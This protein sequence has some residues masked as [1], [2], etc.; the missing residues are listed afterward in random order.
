MGIQKEA[1]MKPALAP[2]P[3]SRRDG[4]TVRYG[5]IPHRTIQEALA[6]LDVFTGWKNPKDIYAFNKFKSTMEREQKKA[7]GWYNKLITK[8]VEMEEVNAK[9]ADGTFS[10]VKDPAT[11]KIKMRAK[12][13]R[14]GRGEQDMVF[15][16]QA[17]FERDLKIFHD[18]TFTVKVH[19]FFVEDLL[20]A[21]LTPVELRSC[22]AIVEEDLGLADDADP[23]LDDIPEDLLGIIPGT[24]KPEEP[25]DVGSEPD[26]EHPT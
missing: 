4:I 8:H 14:N 16:D 25:Q 19:P 23:D 21:G 1:R 17:A 3:D 15:K 13:G 7:A 18:H 6:K 26:N 20:A 5:D 2:P 24:T 12:Q 22:Q 10:P 9:N 11:G